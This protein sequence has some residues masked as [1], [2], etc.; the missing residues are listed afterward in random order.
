[1]QQLSSLTV[2]ISCELC[3][4]SRHRFLFVQWGRWTTPWEPSVVP[5]GG[6]GRPQAVPPSL[7][8]SCRTPHMLW[9]SKQT[10]THTHSQTIHSLNKMI[11]V[12]E[13]KLSDLL[14]WPSVPGAVKGNGFDLSTQAEQRLQLLVIQET[15]WREV[16][17]LKTTRGLM[18]F[19][20]IPTSYIV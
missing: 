19:Y 3:F 16:P 5:G 11:R 15:V 18:L 12:D 17:H 6:Q 2:H 14:K 7:G 10:H 1:M 20:K 8:M 4:C 9:T 13:K